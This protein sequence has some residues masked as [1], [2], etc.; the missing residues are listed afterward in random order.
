MKQEPQ[1][2]QAYQWVDEKAELISGY[3][4]QYAAI[5]GKVLTPQ[6]YGLYISV[7]AAQPN[8]DLARIEKGLKSYLETGNRFPW[9][10]ELIEAIEAEI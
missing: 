8:F 7:I 2:L 9:P 1:P 6:L 3:M 5:A 10:S 4:E